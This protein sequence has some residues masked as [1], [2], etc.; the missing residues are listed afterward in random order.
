METKIRYRVRTRRRSKVS[1]FW[2]HFQRRLIDQK[3]KW[4]VLAL[5]FLIGLHFNS[6]TK[7]DVARADG[8]V[9]NNGVPEPS[10][11]SLLV[12]SGAALLF[13]VRKKQKNP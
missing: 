1:L 5:A 9:I 10:T 12:C 4:V 3:I 8:I 6:E 11:V 13:F 7:R 2:H